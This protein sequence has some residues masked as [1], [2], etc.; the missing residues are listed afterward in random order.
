MQ[1]KLPFSGLRRTVMHSL[2]IN[3]HS[4]IAIQ[5][6][7]Y[8]QYHF[9]FAEMILLKTDTLGYYESLITLLFQM[10][11]IFHIFVHYYVHLILKP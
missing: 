1:V 7:S 5:I 6:H 10:H 9:C 4:L 3:Y 11:T 8:G 2:F